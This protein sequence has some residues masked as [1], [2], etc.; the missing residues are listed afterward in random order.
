MR[1]DAPYSFRFAAHDDMAMLRDW[2]RTPEVARWWGR[3]DVAEKLLRSDLDEPRMVMRIVA[4]ERRAFAY[5]QDY[6]VA[7]WPQPHFAHLPPGTRAIDTFIGEPEMVGRGHGS[8]Y[9]R[10][11]AERLIGEGAPLVAIDP[12]VDNLR[13]RRAYAKAGFRGDT[14]VETPEGVAIVMV[15]GG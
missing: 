1:T 15:Y 2:L 7:S 14:M 10:I 5:A 3:P 13:A 12:A 4:F 11:L 6:A 9:L 8:A